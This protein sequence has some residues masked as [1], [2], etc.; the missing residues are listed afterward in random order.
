[1]KVIIENPSLLSKRIAR[2]ISRASEILELKSECLWDSFQIVSGKCKRVSV[3]TA[4]KRLKIRFIDRFH[5]ALECLE[6]KDFSK[7][8]WI[9]CRDILC[10]CQYKANYSFSSE[11]ELKDWDKDIIIEVYSKDDL[12]FQ[13]TLDRLAK[14][15]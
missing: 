15:L 13:N 4:K 11:Q 8:D 6:S 12:F 10:A 2:V 7:I 1:M 14:R 3:A 5:D 9:D